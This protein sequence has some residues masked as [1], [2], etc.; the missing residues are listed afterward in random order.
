MIMVDDLGMDTIP[1]FDPPEPEALKAARTI[2]QSEKDGRPTWSD[3]T[4]R[5]VACD[6]CVTVL[7]ENGGRGPLPRSARRVR[8][9]KATGERLRLCK[10]H[11]DPRE[12][13]DRTAREKGKRR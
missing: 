8:A 12:A 10:A 5:R 4:A 11:A 3:H 6:E 13:A 1:L 7:H 9:V 2:A